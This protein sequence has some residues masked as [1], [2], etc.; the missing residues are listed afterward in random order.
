MYATYISGFNILG[1]RFSGFSTPG[2]YY[3]Y[4]YGHGPLSG[5]NTKFDIIND[6]ILVGSKVT[7]TG[8]NF[9]ST[10]FSDDNQYIS[11]AF[12][13]NSPRSSL[14]II[15]SGFLNGI[16]IIPPNR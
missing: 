16:Q 7:S 3:L 13:V 12:R 9:N 6:N 2:I 8:V 1:V 5:Q 11:Q 15:C 4:A 10:I 14:T